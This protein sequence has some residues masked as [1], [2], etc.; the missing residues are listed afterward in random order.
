MKNQVRL[1]WGRWSDFAV[2]RVNLRDPA[3][4]LW[5]RKVVM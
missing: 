5:G 4:G 2:I 3:V 1:E